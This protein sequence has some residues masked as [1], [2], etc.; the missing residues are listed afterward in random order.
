MIL[1]FSGTR[2]G[3]TTQQTFQMA[4]IVQDLKPRCVH[5][6]VCK[7]ADKQFND[8]CY[9][10][11]I[12]IYGHPGVDLNGTSPHMGSMIVDRLEL[13]KGYL[14]RNVDIVKESDVLLA[15]PEELQ[16]SHYSGGTWFTIREALKQ[17][18]HT[19]VIF[20]DGSIEEHNAKDWG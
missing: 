14:A 19:I 5:H 1:G 10:Q 18:L 9:K 7:G 2:N 15:T 3:M 20:A 16:G 8:F 11:G 12:Y 6:G 13:P 4:Y 17:K